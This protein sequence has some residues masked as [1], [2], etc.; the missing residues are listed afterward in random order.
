[1]NY[2]IASL[3]AGVGGIDLGFELTG[4]FKT[5]W[6]NEYDKNA[7]ITFRKNFD[8]VL[9]EQ[10]IRSVDTREVPDV[11][12]LISGFP[13]TSFSV[14]GYRKGFED[15]KSGD[16]FFETL[17]FI[18]AKKP[19][20][21]F[22]ENVKNLVS[23]DKGKTFQII[24]DALEENGYK[25]K[26]QV[27]NAKDY[28]NIPQNRERIYIVGFRSE[29]AYHNF[30]FPFPI[31]LTKT[32]KDMFEN[33]VSDEIFYYTEDKN[34]FYK[35]LKEEMNKID[36]IYQ[37]RRKYVRENKSNVCP[38]LTANMG[39]GGHNVPLI[40]TKQG[41]RKLTPRECFNFQGYPANFKL[42]KLANSHLYKQAGNSVV[43]PVINRIAENILKA[44]ENENTNFETQ[45]L[46]YLKEININT[47]EDF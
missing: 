30:E 42:P 26:Y 23:H 5:V 8:A 1:M 28:G 32:I 35:V 20:V 13:C 9:N 19:K 17:R 11:D 45:V 21:I 33:N 24:K 2:K 41:I 3:F 37:W 14:A 47:F 34:A 29:K 40:K 18:V 31:K 43:V 25:I 44:L 6:A 15:E 46:N 7:R 22:L 39:T 4:K 27:L 10:D 16:L 38:T 36:T 12:V